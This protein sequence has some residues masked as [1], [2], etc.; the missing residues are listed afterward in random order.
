MPWKSGWLQDILAL[1]PFLMTGQLKRSTDWTAALFGKLV[2]ALIVSMA[3]G[4]AGGAIGA[5]V[6]LHLQDYRLT[7]LELH[8]REDRQQFQRVQDE[9]TRINERHRQEELNRNGTHP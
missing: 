6:A 9:I 4:A 8:E 2:V 7:Q 3:T 1:L 5:Y